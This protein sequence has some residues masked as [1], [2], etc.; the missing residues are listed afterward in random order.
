MHLPI[1]IAFHKAL[2]TGRH[3]PGRALLIGLLGLG[4]SAPAWASP[5]PTLARYERLRA[6]DLRLATVGYRLAVAN[7]GRCKSGL[8]PQLGFVL[9]SIDQYAQEDRDGAVRA[10]RLTGGVGVM[11]VV[12]TS[13]AEAAGL[14]PDDQI[15]SVNG[16]TLAAV[17]ISARPDRISLEKAQALLVEALV[18]GPVSLGV[19]GRNGSRTVSFAAATGCAS[20]VELVPGDAANA[21]ANGNL[22]TVSEG[23]L[24]QSKTDDDLALVIGHEMA[25]NILHHADNG[26]LRSGLLPMAAAGSRAMRQSEEAADRLAVK[27]ATRAGYDLSRSVSFLRGLLDTKQPL[28]TT[29]PKPDRRLALLRA[30]IA[31]AAGQRG[32]PPVAKTASKD[33]V[34]GRM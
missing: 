13:P 29:H 19:L 14:R 30:A 18:R 10:F 15:V 33:L 20:K 21:W 27:L 7:A 23:L 22:V 28:A 9:H 31:E 6:Q 16:R 5:D 3:W 24:R 17:V 12:A 25:H 34:S 8:L 26:I 2:K 32:P 4:L 11:A 1:P